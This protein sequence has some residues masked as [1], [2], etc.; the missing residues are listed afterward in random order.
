MKDTF[1][2]S[3]AIEVKNIA[4]RKDYIYDLQY[5]IHIIYSI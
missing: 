1:I 3:Q 4:L 5:N 2:P